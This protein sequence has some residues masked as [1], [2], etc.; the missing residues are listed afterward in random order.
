MQIKAMVK[1]RTCGKPYDLL[2]ATQHVCKV[3]F[4]AKRA[5][6]LKKRRGD[7]K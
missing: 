5:K 6:D 4:T 2:R 3:P 1:C 7:K